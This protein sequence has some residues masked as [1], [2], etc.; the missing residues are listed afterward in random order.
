MLFVDVV[1]FEAVAAVKVELVPLAQDLDELF[2]RPGPGLGN[3]VVQ[4]YLWV[5]FVHICNTSKSSVNSSRNFVYLLTRTFL[6]A[7][8]LF[9]GFLGKDFRKNYAD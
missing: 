3:A 4:N 2:H 8:D 6:F 9:H 5:D 7:V 1:L